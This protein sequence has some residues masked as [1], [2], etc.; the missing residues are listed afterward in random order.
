MNFIEIFDIE[1]ESVLGL[2]AC[3]H[4]N[5]PFICHFRRYEIYV[6]IYC[7][8]IG[9]HKNESI[10]KEELLKLLYKYKNIKI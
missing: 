1:F 6:D 7:K 10:I 5:M 3:N 2:V 9:K 4:C 8:M